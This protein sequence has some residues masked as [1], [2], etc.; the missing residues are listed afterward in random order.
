M[1]SLT[2]KPAGTPVTPHGDQVVFCGDQITFKSK[3]PKK[4]PES[5]KYRVEPTVFPIGLDY[6]VTAPR[7]KDGT[8]SEEKTWVRK[9]VV[10]LSAK[11]AVTVCF[12]P[13]DRDAPR[14]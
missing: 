8:L 11:N 14:P 2:E 5:Y 12:A 1:P 7:P 13:M 9:G 4:P 10:A 6:V 3:D